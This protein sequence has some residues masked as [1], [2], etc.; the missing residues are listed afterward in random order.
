V[1]VKKK[2]SQRTG[3]KLGRKMDKK[4]AAIRKKLEKKMAFVD[5]LI[6]ENKIDIALKNLEKVRKES[7]AS[8]FNDIFNK[9]N[10]KI[11]YCNK[12]QREPGYKV[13]PESVVTPVVTTIATTAVAPVLKT[14]E[15]RKYNV[16]L[17]YSTLDSPY[18]QIPKIVKALEKYP[19]IE[20]VLFWEK[21]SGQNIVEFMEATLAKSDVFVLFCSENS[22]KSLAVKDEWQSAFQMR[23]KALMKIIPVYDKEDH[24]PYLLWQL[25]NVQYTK[26]DF[27]GF[28]EKLH[29]EM[30][31]E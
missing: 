4:Q 17:S 24:I 12:L 9:A 21:D 19:D 27:Q 13:E 10:E 11:T 18:F 1:V 8:D 6:K 30:L 23:K 3:T 14:K 29:D 15:K 25:L 22:M 7:D 2:L 28:I 16:F 31:R 5:H 26:D 20:K